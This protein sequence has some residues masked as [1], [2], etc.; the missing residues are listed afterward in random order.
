MLQFRIYIYIYIYIY[1]IVFVSIM[2]KKKAL[3]GFDWNISE[4][5]VVP[6]Q[7]ICQDT[8]P[9][10]TSSQN[11]SK[12]ENLYIY[13]YICID[14]VYFRSVCNNKKLVALI[15]QRRGRDVG[16]CE[17]KTRRLPCLL[18]MYVTLL[19]F[20]LLAYIYLLFFKYL[21]ISFF[22]FN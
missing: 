11:P 19:T 15:V 5:F 6:T 9:L 1:W 16:D 3:I 2:L 17:T 20:L 14:I 21:F 4:P 12:I 22:V 7:L 10:T 18:C 13:I 8:S